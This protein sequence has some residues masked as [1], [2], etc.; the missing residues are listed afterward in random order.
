M[1]LQPQDKTI[2][3][4]TYRVTPLV[5]TQGRAVFVRLAKMLGSAAAGGGEKGNLYESLARVLE[6]LNETDL[7]FI[8]D[9]FARQ[10]QLQMERGWV[11]LS[12]AFDLHFAQRYLEMFQW[13]AFCLEV[14]Y[15][16][17]F[18]GIG[19]DVGE[20]LAALVS[21]RSSSPKGV[22]GSSGGS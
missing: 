12:D 16:G 2:G 7:A 22:T 5:A 3:G 15:S 11:Q 14:N 18:R 17:F 6:N 9:A 21:S 10:T 1:A 13:L 8:S 4:S 20:G 19:A